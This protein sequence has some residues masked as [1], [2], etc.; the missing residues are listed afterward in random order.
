MDVPL[1]NAVGYERLFPNHVILQSKI[2]LREKLCFQ[3]YTWFHKLFGEDLN[4]EFSPLLN[5]ESCRN[6]ILYEI[7]NA[8]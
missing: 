6:A 1:L 2:K 3:K 8:S 7:K 4:W 5:Y